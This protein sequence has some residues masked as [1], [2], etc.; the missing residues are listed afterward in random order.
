MLDG[1]ANFVTFRPADARGL[2]NALMARGLILREYPAG[3]M[4]GWL[5]A[6]ARAR[7]ENHR[8]IAALAELLG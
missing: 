4:G 2:A 1:V 6:T 3:P 5:R 8:L 7:D